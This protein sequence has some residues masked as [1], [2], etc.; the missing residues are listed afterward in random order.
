V[1]L[2]GIGLF[3]GNIIARA[4]AV[5]VASISL[6]VNFFFI[7]VYP[8]W[9]LTVI[10]IDVLVIWAVTAHGREMREA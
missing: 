7:P 1:L 6:L 2:S 4:V 8:L 10:V 9:A 3:S 5:I